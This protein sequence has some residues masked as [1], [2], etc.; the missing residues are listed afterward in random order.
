MQEN[1]DIRLPRVI[2]AQAQE[3]R[4]L[5]PLRLEYTLKMSPLSTARITLP[6]SDPVSVG[7][8]VELYDTGGSIGVFRVYQTTQT[9]VRGGD[10]VAE[11]EHA[12]ST[13]SDGVA[14]GYR[15]LGG[16]G[17]SLRTVLEALLALQPVKKWALGTCEFS[18]QFQYS[19]ENENLL[20]AILSLAEPLAEEYLWTFDTSVYPF[21]LNLLKAP[22][23]DAS[24]MRMNRN[25]D[26]VQVEID[27]SDLC[28]RIYPLG[29]GEGVNQL[30]I[31]GVN[32]NKSYIDADTVSTWGV[33]AGTYAET[34]VTEVETLKAMAVS[35]LEKLKN[36]T[37]TVTAKGTDIYALTGETMDK[38][39]VGR[40]C[41]VPLPDYGIAL[42]ERVVSIQKTDV[43][44]NNTNVTVTMANEKRDSVSV[45]ANLSRRTAIGELYSQGS[46]N[47]Y[48]V[49]F[50]DNADA[51]N[52]LDCDFYIDQNA[53]W[54]NSVMCKFKLEAFRTY[55]KGAASG[56]GST[57]SAGGQQTATTEET[58]IVEYPYTG[59]PR[60]T[61]TREFISNTGFATVTSSNLG[62]AH[63]HSL[64]HMHRIEAIF[65]VPPLS[66]SIKSHTHSTPDHVH[67][68]NPGIYRGS[69][70]DSVTVKVD[71]TAVPASAIVNGEFDAVPYLKKDSSGR[72]VRGSWHTITFTPDSLTRVV[73]DLHVKTFIRSISGGNY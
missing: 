3:V 22:T 56:G 70:A 17:V 4:R 5:R 2:D 65:K 23:G 67:P 61:E 57:T 51:A 19:F 52:S 11:L 42:D 7:E 29:Y 30:N 58:L 1:I 72:I 46:A 8:F 64:L 33:V 34:T 71:E 45:M 12:L 16:S 35:V 50:A 59:N 55:T 28:T 24:E 36:P 54:I 6:E 48:A 37:V 32:N 25:V 53:V 14:F 21:V 63:Y 27:R 31:T 26:S 15:E 47:Q 49:H 43:F 13:L 10:I 38:F 62:E 20:T 41:R 9:H 40:L 18:T 44:G 69:T 60:S 39:Y 73:A 68:D 66:V